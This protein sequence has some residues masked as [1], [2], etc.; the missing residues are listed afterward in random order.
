MKTILYSL[1]TLSVFALLFW[2]F[3][4]EWVRIGVLIIMLCYIFLFAFGGLYEMVSDVIDGIRAD[5]KYKKKKN[6]L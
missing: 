2:I 6:K 1:V 4:F 3:T 5:I